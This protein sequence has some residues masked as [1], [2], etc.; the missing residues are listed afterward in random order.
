MRNR[1]LSLEVKDTERQS[2]NFDSR[3]EDYAPR[4]YSY[5]TSAA[6]TAKLLIIGGAIFALLWVI[7]VLLTR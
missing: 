5:R 7:D 3:S 1:N 2:G 4:Q 6:L